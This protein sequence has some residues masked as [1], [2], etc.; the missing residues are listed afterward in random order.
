MV[1]IEMRGFSRK[2]LNGFLILL[3]LL[4][5][6]TSHLSLIDA[7]QQDEDE[8]ADDIL[9]G[10]EADKDPEE[11][12]RKL[13]DEPP[14]SIANATDINGL[15]YEGDWI[16]YKLKAPQNAA[17]VIIHLTAPSGGFVDIYCANFMGVFTFQRLLPIAP[18]YI[19]SSNHRAGNDT[20]FISREDPNAVFGAGQEYQC[21]I[22]GIAHSS[23]EISSIPYTLSYSF[24]YDE[25]TINDENRDGIN[26][27]YDKC[28]EME[29]DACPN[30]KAAMSRDRDRWLVIVL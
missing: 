29:S 11:P 30:W 26:Q 15:I 3:L 17:D 6:L 25:R 10:D 2:R 8:S 16:T 19:W 24:S 21:I 28:C 4:V 27:L 20:I 14:V 9:D 7:Q 18:F 22:Y 23:V 13:R 1:G 12:P 5:T